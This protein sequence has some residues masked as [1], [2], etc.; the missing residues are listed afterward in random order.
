MLYIV[1]NSSMGRA[2]K[3]EI[4]SQGVAAWYI[5]LWGH[6]IV[7]TPPALEKLQSRRR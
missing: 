6:Y 4:E 1:E 2:L 3:E 5:E 7:A